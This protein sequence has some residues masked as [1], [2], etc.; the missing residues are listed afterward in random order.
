MLTAIK[1][2]RATRTSGRRPNLS[3]NEPMNGDATSWASAKAIV[4]NPSVSTP[5]PNSASRLA[6]TGMIMPRPVIIN[7]TLAANSKMMLRVR[8]GLGRD[9][10][11]CV[12]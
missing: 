9:V 6:K 8:C 11:T 7:A 4:I 2:P 5:E 10:I 1:E 3:A 12:A